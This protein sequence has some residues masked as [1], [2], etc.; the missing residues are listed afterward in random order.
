MDALSAFFFNLERSVAQHKQMLLQGL[1][2]LDSESRAELDFHLTLQ[3]LTAVV[4]QLNTDCLVLRSRLVATGYTKLGHLMSTGLAAMN[5]KTGIRS[6]RLLDQVMTEVQR[7]LPADYLGFLND[8]SVFS[9]VGRKTLYLVCVKV[10]QAHFLD[11]DLST[12]KASHL[13]DEK[14]PDAWVRERWT[15]WLCSWGW[16]LQG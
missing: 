3:D 6:G 10:S 14:E 9:L 2:Q 8:P 7:S 11:G 1:P 5:E 13:E 16:W 12:S 4:G 15:W